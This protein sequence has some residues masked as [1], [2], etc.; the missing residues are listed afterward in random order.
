LARHLSSYAT[1][2]SGDLGL[3]AG[4]SARETL[5]RHP[6]LNQGLPAKL[7]PTLIVWTAAMILVEFNLRIK[8][9]NGKKVS[10]KARAEHLLVR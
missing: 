3:F 5:R 9:E 2:G 6:N 10:R 4:E 1:F 8:L 7:L